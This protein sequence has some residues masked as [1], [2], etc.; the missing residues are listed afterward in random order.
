MWKYPRIP[1]SGFP[2]RFF[3][4]RFPGREAE[5][6]DGFKTVVQEPVF[7]FE[8]GPGIELETIWFHEHNHTKSFRVF[9]R[10][11][12]WIPYQISCRD[13]GFHLGDD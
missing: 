8:R 4:G 6:A 7:F 2:G 12:W 5:V 10:E 3:T 1:K 11:G 9:T 13:G